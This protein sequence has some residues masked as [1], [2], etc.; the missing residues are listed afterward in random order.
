MRSKDEMNMD[1][2]E[3]QTRPIAL[4]SPSTSGSC[5]TN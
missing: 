3:I 5:Y 4:L 2:H 1:S